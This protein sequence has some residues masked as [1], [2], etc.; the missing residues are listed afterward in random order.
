MRF[1]TAD[2]IFPITSP[3]IPDGVVVAEDDGTIIRVGKRDDPDLP[4]LPSVLES[5]SGIICPGFIN[6]HCHLEL[7]HLKNKLTAGKGLPHF[8]EEMMKSRNGKDDEIKEAIQK[9]ESEMITGGIVAVGDISNGRH[10]F[11]QKKKHRLR[12]HTFI[13][14]FDIVPEKA[15]V[16]FE[17]AL[18]LINEF[19]E[20]TQPLNTHYPIAN[21]ISITPHAPYST[22]PKLLKLINEYAYHHGSPLSIHNQE[23][24]SENA[25]FVERKG[26]LF[27]VLSSFGNAYAN[28]KATGFS[29]LSSSLVHLPKCN[30]LQLVHNTFS[31]ADD[32]TWAHLY[33]MMTWWCT[34]PNANL[35]IENKLPDYQL[36]IDAGCRMT[37]GTDSYASNRSL[38]M[39][40][41]LKT[42]STHAP[43]IRLETLL[44]WA[45]MNG[46]EFLGF[47]KESGSLEKG[48][49]P[50][51]NLIKHVDL[52]KISLTIDSVVE[53]IV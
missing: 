23:T 43:F 16:E 1:I 39:L 27:D 44:R 50:G 12:Y 5:F 10:S 22:T 34:C 20:T 13:E 37:V 38:S 36:F 18:N 40:D 32:I 52:E 35:F 2:F 8:I 25:M 48:K 53:K 45:T 4:P 9:A 46:A 11:D 14:V 31:T 42:I 17:R 6:A 41:E 7:S 21:T 26:K 30:K 28:W 49:K 51:L 19:D 3:P 15:D 47:N 33:N 24:A 29:S